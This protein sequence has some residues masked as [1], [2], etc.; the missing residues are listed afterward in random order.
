[1][2]KLMSNFVEV[3]ANFMKGTDIITGESVEKKQLIDERNIVGK[4]VK[5]DKFCN[6][7]YK[8]KVRLFPGV[9]RWYKASEIKDLKNV[10]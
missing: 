1:M 5:E 8:Y 6:S 7:K 9:Y 4:I 2:K 10:K 3:K